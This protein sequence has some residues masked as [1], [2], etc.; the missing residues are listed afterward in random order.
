[1]SEGRL[2]PL[3][4][5]HEADVLVI[6]DGPSAAAAAA[7]LE[8]ARRGRRVVLLETASGAAA[9]S[10]ADLGCIPTGPALPYSEAA[11]R[12][13]RSTAGEIWQEYRESHERLRELLASLG[14]DCGYRQNGGFLLALERVAGMALADSEDLLREDGFPGEFLDHYMFEARFDL[15]GF[16]GAYWAADD[17]ELDPRAFARTLRT[18]VRN[19][20]ARVHGA[21]PG[22]TLDLST[23]GAHAATA[24]G[25]VKAPCAL[26]ALEVAAFHLLPGLEE[27]MVALQGGRLVGRMPAGPSLPA[28]ARVLGDGCAWRAIES[29]LR[30]VRLSPG[31]TGGAEGPADAGLDALE[32]FLGARLSAP[33]RRVR[34][35]RG[36]AAA[37]RDGFPLVGL[38][39]GRPAALIAGL[40]GLGHAYTLT[41]ARWAA[42]ALVVGADP[43]PPRLRAA[44]AWKD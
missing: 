17:G 30:A 44:R 6:G 29:E 18:A 41:A 14:R 27:R 22:L 3:E 26:L 31:T 19:A 4:G 9:L 40:A 38:L 23:S 34:R 16:A 35:W 43:T 21:G 12:W 1:V 42:E 8:L 13:G 33:L 25:S 5:D 20:G 7:A 10:S 37:S 32:V 36:T 15:R 2:S 11:A 24:Q 39:P 28:T